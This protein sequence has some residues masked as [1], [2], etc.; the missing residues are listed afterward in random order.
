MLR[1]TS[2]G[3]VSRLRLPAAESLCLSESKGARR[4]GWQNCWSLAVAQDDTAKIVIPKLTT[5]NRP[6]ATALRRRRI[7]HQKVL[8]FLCR[9][10]ALAVGPRGNDRRHILRA[11][12]EGG[13]NVHRMRHVGLHPG[14]H[15]RVL[16]RVEDDQ[17]D[18]RIH[19]D[20]L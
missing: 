2:A 12:L 16:R 6:L 10:Q 1:S 15:G 20:M 17:L 4:S 5:D 9:L 14:V 19:A 7:L 13:A 8:E 3:R 18:R 11:G